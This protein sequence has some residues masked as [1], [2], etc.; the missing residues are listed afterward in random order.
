MVKAA[1]T[2]TIGS[3][4]S[5]RRPILRSE[6]NTISRQS[7]ATCMPSRLFATASEADAAIEEI[8]E[9]YSNAKDE[10]EMAAEETEKKT[11]YAED[12]RAAAQEELQKLKDTYDRML[13]QSAPDVASEIK[14]RVGQR[15]RELD[16]AIKALEESAQED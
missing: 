3:S 15:I 14:N 16:N 9:L 10:F 11:V 13:Q 2:P 1:V 8:Q 4:N 7:L 12:D 6:A 5:L